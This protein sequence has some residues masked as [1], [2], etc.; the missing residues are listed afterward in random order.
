MH[1]TLVGDLVACKP[2]RF[3][4]YHGSTRLP[5]SER[6][7]PPFRFFLNN[8][9]RVPGDGAR[10]RRADNAERGIPLTARVLASLD[11]LAESV[12]VE[13]VARLP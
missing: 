4:F 1:I 10:V 8:K 9:V 3:F 11:E 5:P 12:G 6:L 7:T 13:P 2:A